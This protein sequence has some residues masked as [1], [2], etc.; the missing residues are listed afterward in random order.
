MKIFSFL[1]KIG[2]SRTWLSS[3]NLALRSLE[4]NILTT[5]GTTWRTKSSGSSPDPILRTGPSTCAPGADPKEKALTSSGRILFW[6]TC[7]GKSSSL[8]PSPE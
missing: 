5:Q 6:A 2:K 8:A 1:K 7:G 4:A 3:L